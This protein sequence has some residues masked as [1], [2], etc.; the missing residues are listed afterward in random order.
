MPFVLRPTVL[1]HLILDRSSLV[2]YQPLRIALGW[3]LHPQGTVRGLVIVVFDPP[4][5][6]TRYV[7]HRFETR[8]IDIVPLEA[9]KERLGQTVRLRSPPGSVAGDEPHGWRVHFEPPFV[10]W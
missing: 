8:L 1:P 9:A 6:L 4:Q 2:S 7:F 3:R 10:I 5:E